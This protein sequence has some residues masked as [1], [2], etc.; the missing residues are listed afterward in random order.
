MTLADRPEGFVEF[1][2]ARIH[3]TG[4]G[5]GTALVFVHAGIADSRMWRPQIAFFSPRYR[6]ITFDLRGFGQT[7]MA[8][9]EYSN[10]DD[11]EAVMDALG[12][13]KAAL[14]GCSMGGSA[15]INFALRNPQRALALVPVCSGVEGYEVEDTEG[16]LALWTQAQEARRQG[17]F[18][19]YAEAVCR[20]WVDGPR[21]KPEAVEPGVRA[22][23]KEMLRTSFD[24]PGKSGKQVVPSPLMVNRLGEIRT[25]TLVIAGREDVPEMTPHIQ[26]LSAEIQGARLAVIEGAGHLPGLEQPAEFN[27]L[28]DDFLN[29]VL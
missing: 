20:L 10:A 1:N 14:V 13:E 17:D 3:F 18:E 25:P 21:R 15:A 8:A 23:V 6:V 24:T 29:E 26:K 4:T 11:L 9:G 19:C 27:R 7:A 5:E 12:V 16:S 28:L 2:G 22:F